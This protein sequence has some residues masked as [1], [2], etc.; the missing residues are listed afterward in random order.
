MRVA[1]PTVVLHLADRPLGAQVIVPV[2]AVLA[3]LG[4]NTHTPQTARTPRS[5]GANPTER[6]GWPLVPAVGGDPMVGVPGTRVVRV[7]RAGDG[8]SMMIRRA[9]G[10]VVGGGRAGGWVVG[11]GR[12]GGVG[13]G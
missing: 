10:W 4:G 3:P 6:V 13:V 5:P 7:T 8:G 2:A 11:G 12:A 1:S 9:G